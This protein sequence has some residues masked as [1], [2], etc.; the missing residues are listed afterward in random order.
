MSTHAKLSAINIAGHGLAVIIS[1]VK[2]GDKKEYVSITDA[3]IYID[4]SRTTRRNN[5]K[6]G[7]IKKN[8]YIIILKE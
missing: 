6:S 2:T 4:V 8:K 3:A 5:L 1:N 7:K